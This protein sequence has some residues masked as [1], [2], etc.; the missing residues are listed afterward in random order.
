MS[1]KFTNYET[2]SLRIGEESGRLVEV[3]ETLANYFDQ[4]LEQRRQLVSALSYPVMIVLS[5][6]GAIAFMMLTIIPMFEEVFKRFGSELP[7]LTKTIITFSNFIN[8]NFWLILIALIAIVVSFSVLKKNDKVNY[9]M[10]SFFM[11]IPYIGT[12]YL[13]IQ[14]SRC[15]ASMALLTKASVPLTRAIEFVGQMMTMKHLQE[16]LARVKQEIIRGHQLHE[17]LEHEVLFDKSF[18]SLIRV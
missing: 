16:S 10:E 7:P 2:F 1:G 3:L 11:K 12:L 4:K 17:A 6:V 13:D 14:L 8:S 18:V 5:S 9:W 15:S